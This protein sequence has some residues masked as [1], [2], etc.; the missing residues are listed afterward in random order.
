MKKFVNVELMWASVNEVNS[1]S[2]KYQVDLVNLEP[3]KIDALEDAGLSVRTKDNAPDMGTFITAKSQY[4]ILVTDADGTQIVDPVGNGTKADV[5][6]DTYSWNFKGKKGLSM[7]IKKIIV[8][9]LV[10]YSKEP[11]DLEAEVDEVL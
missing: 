9:D 2:N 10:P 5:I 8:T 7:S 6:W 4:P 1:M 11:T 3:A